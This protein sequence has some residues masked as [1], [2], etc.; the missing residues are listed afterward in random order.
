ML[1]TVPGTVWMT[2]VGA[3][4]AYGRSFPPSTT[5]Q[6]RAARWMIRLATSS[7]RIAQLDYYSFD[8]GGSF[9]SALLWPNGT[10]RPAYGVFA[11][12]VRSLRG[13]G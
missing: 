2:E 12:W 10:P 3:L 4:Y 1:A 8:L 5:R 9:D 6:T 7:P 11:N 13:T